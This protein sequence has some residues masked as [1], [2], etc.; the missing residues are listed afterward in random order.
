MLKIACIPVF[1][2]EGVIEEVVKKTL[3]YVD[4]VIVCDDGSND[5]T[6]KEAK[7]A[8]AYVIEH[9]KNLGKVLP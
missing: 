5:N 2:E 7:D 4:K 8:G 1:N 9:K 3:S 6:V